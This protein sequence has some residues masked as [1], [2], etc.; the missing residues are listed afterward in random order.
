MTPAIEAKRSRRASVGKVIAVVLKLAVTVACFSYVAWQVDL[1]VLAKTLPT[2]DPAWVGLAL[3]GAMLQILLVGLR[4]FA[5]LEALPG[6]RASRVDAVAITWIS[7][8][9]GQI[10]P[11]AAG[12]AMRVWLASRVGRD[13]HLGVISVLIDRGVGVAALFACGFVILLIPSSLAMMDGYGGPLAVSF[14]LI[15]LGVIVGLVAVPWVAPLLVRSTYTHWIGIAASASYDV[16]V[17]SRTGIVVAILAFMVHAITIGCIWCVGRALGMLLPL[18]DAAVLFVLMLSIALVP[19][20]I[21]GWGLREAAVVTLLGSSGVRPEMALS[22]SVIFGLVPV[23]SS[24]PGA[25]VWAV[26]SPF[27]PTGES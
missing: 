26:Y 10:L 18:L 22:L 5:I 19:V 12:D 9:V 11:Y 6:T 4:W 17:K 13:W 20:S 1:S 3:V 16:L 24:L 15:S 23:M 25:I 2:I 8:L 27:K 7:T 14:G 21:G